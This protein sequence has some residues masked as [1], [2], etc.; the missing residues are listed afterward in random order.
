MES[1]TSDVEHILSN[2]P[3]RQPLK[4]FIKF[5]ISE[6]GDAT[7]LAIIRLDAVITAT[8]ENLKRNLTGSDRGGTK[9][10]VVAN[11][12]F[13]GGNKAIDCI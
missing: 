9:Q 11:Y 6:D 4:Y 5:K 8:V 10:S 3:E 1:S 13:L 12:D 7:V 2:E